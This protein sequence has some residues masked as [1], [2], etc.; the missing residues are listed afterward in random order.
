MAFDIWR[1]ESGCV[2]LEG[3]F[4]AAH[5]ERAEAVFSEVTGPCTVDFSKLE[6]VASAGLSVLLATQR[7][8][9]DDGSGLVLKGLSKHITDL[10]RVAGFDAIFEIE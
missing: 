8:L 9:N 2:H 1:D 7:R 10:F 4:H 3:K 6:Y 5:V